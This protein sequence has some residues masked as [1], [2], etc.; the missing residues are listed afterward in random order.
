MTKLKANN[1]KFTRSVGTT[2]IPTSGVVISSASYARELTNP[3]PTAS[4]YGYT[5]SQHGSKLLVGDR[6]AT[7]SGVQS[8]RAYIY[9][10]STGSTLHTLDNPN[11]FS[12]LND[13]NFGWSVKLT[14]NHAIVAA[15][16][17]DETGGVWD[18]GKVYIFDATT[19][20]LVHTI[21]NPNTYSTP[22][23]DKFGQSVDANSSLIVVSAMEEDSIATSAG[24]VYLFDVDNYTLL[25]TIPAPV[26]SGGYYFGLHV[27]ISETHLVVS[28]QGSNGHIHVYDISSGDGTFS[29]LYSIDNPAGTFTWFERSPQ[30]SGNNLVVPALSDVDGGK[31]YVYDIT[32]GN[33]L[34]TIDN[35]NIAS[36]PDGDQFGY[37]IDVVGNYAVVG[38]PG[39]DPGGLTIGTAYI[40]DITTGN[41]VTTLDSGDTSTNSNTYGTGCTIDGN[42]ACVTRGLHPGKIKVFDLS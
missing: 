28:Q 12:T 33:L 29:F 3:N 20:G 32:T 22:H 26:V 7:Q 37:S 41:V 16:H 18:S 10:L 4:Y 40:V 19:G 14:A 27:S 38:A 36:T 24:A 15:T 1:V 42:Y 23:G 2:T 31:V 25:N 34:R 17:E 8:G 5:M 13:D 6:Q 9:D 35:P 21:N 30:I 11:A 39:E